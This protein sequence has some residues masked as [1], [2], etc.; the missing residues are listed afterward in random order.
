MCR[1]VAS[2]VRGRA[3]E[4]GFQVVSSSRRLMNARMSFAWP[5]TDAVGNYGRGVL[6][7]GAGAITAHMNTILRIPHVPFPPNNVSG[8]L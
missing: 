8:S 1:R 6:E 5:T 3:G 7:Q 4:P 2:L